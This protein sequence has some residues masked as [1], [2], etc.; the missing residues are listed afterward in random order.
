MQCESG[1]KGRGLG[2]ISWQWQAHLCTQPFWWVLWIHQWTHPPN[3][4]LDGIGMAPIDS[5]HG[6]VCVGERTDIEMP[7][8]TSSSP[9]SKLH[10]SLMHVRIPAKQ[11]LQLSPSSW[12]TR[13]TKFTPDHCE[14]HLHTAPST[15]CMSWR[16]YAHSHGHHH[17]RR[18]SLAWPNDWRLS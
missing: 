15:G 13:S 14:I 1:W 12:R 10:Q 3:T 6:C 8:R 11:R 9:W 5:W 2:K 7:L 16:M 4:C 17:I 18:G